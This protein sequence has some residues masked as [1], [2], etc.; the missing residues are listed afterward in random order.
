MQSSVSSAQLKYASSE[1]T[2]CLPKPMTC[3]AFEDALGIAMACMALCFSVL[4]AIVLGIFVKHQDTPIV[5]ANNQALNFIL[6]IFLLSCFLCSLLFIGH[7]NTVTCVLQQVAF[8]LVFTV[9]VSTVLAK[10]IAVILAFKAM[11]PG[12]TI[13]CL[14]LSGDSNSGISICFLIQMIICGIWL[15]TSPPFIDIHSHSPPRS[16]IIVCNKGSVTAFYC[17]LGYLGFLA[18]GSF[19]VAFLARNLPDT[20]SEAK[21]LTFIMLVFCSVWVTFVP[22]YLSTKGKFMVAVEVFFILASSVG[23]LDCIFVPKCYIMLIRPD[24]NSWKALKKQKRLQ[25]TYKVYIIRLHYSFRVLNQKGTD[26]IF[27]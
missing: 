2:H 26:F 27:L 23:L 9:A 3:L 17:V 14:L 6:L 8:D 15:G 4:T 16:L 10:T 5:K 19:T 24:K 20:F 25:I 22:I 11:K 12:R 1:R 18:L 21:F 13:R 7:S